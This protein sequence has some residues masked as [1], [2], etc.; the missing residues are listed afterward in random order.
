LAVVALFADGA[1]EITNI[2]HVRFKETDR[3]ADL[4][5]DLRRFGAEVEE[6]QDGLRIIPPA[7]LTPAIVK[8]YDDHRMAMSFAIAGLKLPGVAIC[9]PECTQKTF[10]E[11]F[12]VLENL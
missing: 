12:S 3:I 4:A 9:N 11:F 8:T 5:T 1:T 10:P 7:I 2:E 6:R